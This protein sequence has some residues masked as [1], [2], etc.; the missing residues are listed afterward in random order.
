MVGDN[1]LFFSFGVFFW[2]L[3]FQSFVKNIMCL[4]YLIEDYNVHFLSCE[5]VRKF[6]CLAFGLGF[7]QGMG[8]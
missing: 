1:T 2:F 5:F 8:E 7:P 3:K 6:I 4:F